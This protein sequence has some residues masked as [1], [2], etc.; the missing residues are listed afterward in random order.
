MDWIGRGAVEIPL[1]HCRAAP[2]YGQGPNTTSY[3]LL[4]DIMIGKKLEYINLIFSMQHAVTA[5]PFLGR[6]ID[7]PDDD[8]CAASTLSRKKKCVNNPNNST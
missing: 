4:S 3:T 7:D 2:E 5:V 8:F 1:G 6:R